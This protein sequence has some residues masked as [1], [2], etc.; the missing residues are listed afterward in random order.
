MICIDMLVRLA[1]SYETI[2]SM[3]FPSHMLLYLWFY[4]WWLNQDL[5]YTSIRFNGHQPAKVAIPLKNNGILQ[6][7]K[8]GVS[9]VWRIVLVC[10]LH[11]HSSLSYINHIVSVEIWTSAMV[12]AS[13]NGC[14]RCRAVPGTWLEGKNHPFFHWKCYMLGG[15]TKP[16]SSGKI[17]D[18]Y[19]MI[20]GGF[21][22]YAVL[23]H[24]QTQPWG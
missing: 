19:P 24:L 17:E 16:H 10:P 12:P 7:D 21:K 18:L 20:M 13:G 11:H 5:W 8:H 3:C 4:F 1:I 2:F 6:R 23:A 15:T 14:Q 9:E 22:G